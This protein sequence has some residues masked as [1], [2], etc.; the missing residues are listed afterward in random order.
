MNIRTA[1]IS[2]C[3][4]AVLPALAQGLHKEIDVKQ[5]IEPVKREASRITVLPSL[6]L[7]PIEKPRLS[8]SDRTVTSR[9]PNLI[10]TLDPMAYGDTLYVSPYRGYVALGVG[11]PLLNTLFSAGYR[12]IDNDKTRLS[13]WSQ[14][15]GDIYTRSIPVEAEGGGSRKMY[16]RDHTASIGA[17]LHQAVGKKSFIDAGADYTY[18][19]HNVPF[20]DTYFG[21]NMSR[22]NMQ[23]I[24]SSSEDELD[25]TIAARWRHFGFY[26]MSGRERLASE[27]IYEGI[28][29]L[30]QNLFGLGATSK[31]DMSDDSE[32]GLDVDADF[33]RTSD[34]LNPVYPFTTTAFN[35][36]RT[37]GLIALHPHYTYSTQTLRLRLGAEVDLSINDGK[38]LHISPEASV[39][40][41]PSQLI[42]LEA[43]ATGGAQLN[44]LA[45][46]YDVTPYISPFL[47]YGQSHIPYAFDGKVTLGPVFG[48]YIELF[49]GYAKADSWLMPMY[50]DELPA[51]ALFN[52]T[53]VSSWHLGA[54]VGYDY[55][56]KLSARIS[57]ETAPNDYD[58][59]Y[60][61]W[62]DRARHVVS[63]DLKVRPV[64]NVLV[65]LGYEFRTGRRLFTPEEIDLGSAPSGESL[66]VF[67]NSP[68][69]LGCVS[70][71]SLGA[72]LTVTDPLT[73][74]ARG[75]NL[76]NR[77][78]CHIGGR[79][80]QGTNFMVGASLKF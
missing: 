13:L 18:A 52:A 71:L 48:A 63:A 50:A 77:R 76:L 54:A 39:A 57:Y 34:Y 7:T 17:D 26:H 31:V 67:T 69:N 58:K 44:P 53:D 74:F 4:A 6:R 9:V 37:S 33:L 61:M 73:I 68:L 14:Y 8:F 32:I 22:A 78:F 24:F 47:A 51:G 15:D 46:L 41:T 79:I 42:A 20:A 27:E 64:K 35:T 3:L 66:T 55:R 65:T 11:T 10:T 25:Y 72:A 49:G 56:D 45:S 1:S 59:C 5:K 43:K 38:A 70:N 16:W 40:W 29:T 36:A 80:S 28:G 19:Y 30:R 62:R 21:Q 2:L 60:Y 12:A 75:E 23:A